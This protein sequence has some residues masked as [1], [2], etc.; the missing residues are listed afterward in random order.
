MALVHSESDRQRMLRGLGLAKA[1]ELF[2]GI[3]ES[4]KLKR[5]LAVPGPLSEPELRKHFLALGEA[6]AS[7][8]DWVSFL[9]AG[10]YEHYIPAVVNH[11][12][13]RGE[14]YTSYTPYQAEI[15]QGLLQSIYEYQRMICRLTGMEVSNASLYDG[16]SAVA[17][18][19]C[20]PLGGPE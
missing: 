5:P 15:S 20:Y 7:L 8:Q 3:P 1:E 11:V 18:A 9:G 10:V 13:R 12:L 19:V 17:E 16:A 6:N 2:A 4:V 14:F